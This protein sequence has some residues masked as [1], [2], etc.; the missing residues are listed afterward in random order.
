LTCPV[1]NASFASDYDFDDLG[2]LV[3]D[4]TGRDLFLT[5][6][7]LARL[8]GVADNASPPNAS[9]FAYD[10]VG[11]RIAVVDAKGRST[12]FTYDDLDRLVAIHQAAESLTTSFTYDA[13]GN[14]TRVTDPKLQETD[15]A[16]DALSRLLSVEQPLGQIV[17]YAYDGRG[18]LSSTTNARGH[19]LRYAYHSW[20]G[21]ER[22]EEFVDASAGTPTK[23]VSY[24][25]DH[26]GSGPRYR[27]AIWRTSLAKGRRPW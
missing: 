9:G 17:A 3:T 22:V 10:A 6:D 27:C 23:T 2:R 18:R 26:E 14:V 13:A 15:Y 19:V 1:T 12:T 20:G 11:N 21:L 7:D 5:Y 24:T 4:A 16:Y 8:T 25:Y